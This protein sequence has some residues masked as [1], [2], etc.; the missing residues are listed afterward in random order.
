[1]Q[2]IKISQPC[3]DDSRYQSALNSK[4]ISNS[5]ILKQMIGMR[6]EFNR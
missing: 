3:P 1:V 4:T 5:A 6:N 2:L